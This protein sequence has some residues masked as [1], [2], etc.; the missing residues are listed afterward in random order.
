MQLAYEIHSKP[1][2]NKLLART[3]SVSECNLLPKAKHSHSKELGELW[4]QNS[5]QFNNKFNENIKYVGD[6]CLLDHTTLI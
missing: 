2:L 3:N 6:G 4:L 1:R 5:I